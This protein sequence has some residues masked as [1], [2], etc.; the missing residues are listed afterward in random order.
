MVA[1]A[2][3][4][5]EPVRV[6]ARFCCPPWASM[7]ACITALAELSSAVWQVIRHSQKMTCIEPKRSLW[8]GIGKEHAAIDNLDLTIDSVMFV[9]GFW[10]HSDIRSAASRKAE[11]L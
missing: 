4:V 9:S 5:Y 6:L 2:F 1:V 10:K 11:L 8:R 3:A 7:A